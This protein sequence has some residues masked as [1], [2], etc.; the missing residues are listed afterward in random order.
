MPIVYRK[1]MMGFNRNEANAGC[2]HIG[3]D[4]AFLLCRNVCGWRILLQ[5]SAVT[6]DVVRPIHLGRRG[7]PPTP[8]LSTQ[9]ERYAIHK[10]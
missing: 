2:R 5:K 3:S 9:L 1:A 6:N 4:L 7:L 10:A 8:M